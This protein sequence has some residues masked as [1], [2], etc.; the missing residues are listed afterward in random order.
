MQKYRIM[1]ISFFNTSQDFQTINWFD[2]IINS[3]L[4]TVLIKFIFK[5]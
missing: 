2:K 4:I 3:L 5:G 1:K